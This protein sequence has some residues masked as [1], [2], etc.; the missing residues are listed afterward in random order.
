MAAS[1]SRLSDAC[2]TPSTWP[3]CAGLVELKVLPVLDSTQRP[4]M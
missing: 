1:A 4:P 2:I 3:L